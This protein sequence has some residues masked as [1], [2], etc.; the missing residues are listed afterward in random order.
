MNPETA[1]AITAIVGLLSQGDWKTFI[2]IV[3]ALL[4]GPWVFSF[5]MA[6]INE[7]RYQAMEAM[8]KNNVKLVEC[9]EKLAA[10]QNDTI[11]LN[12]A[13]WQEVSDKIDTNQYCPNN[14]TRKQRMEDVT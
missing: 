3:L 8:Y 7:K 13:K 14:R 2:G 10:E 6:R 11:T 9:F 12:T 4:F 1:Q 5:I